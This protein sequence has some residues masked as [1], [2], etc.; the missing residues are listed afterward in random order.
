MGCGGAFVNAAAP[1]A[2]QAP[3]SPSVPSVCGRWPA[4]CRR[5][6]PHPRGSRQALQAPDTH[7][8]FHLP[9][10]RALLSQAKVVYPWDEGP[11]LPGHAAG[12][13][14][15]QTRVEQRLCPR[16]SLHLTPS[17]AAPLL[18]TPVPPALASIL[19]PPCGCWIFLAVMMPQQR[20]C[21]LRLFIFFKMF[22]ILY[23]L[24]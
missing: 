23:L 24:Q 19:W 6:Q 22:V 20:P 3:S 4:T 15:G 7:S 5:C 8:R 13:G 11:E 9:L 12:P 14:V 18:H 16:L 1:P 21:P 17:P 10:G 2:P